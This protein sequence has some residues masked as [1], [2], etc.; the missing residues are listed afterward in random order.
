[1]KNF[2]VILQATLKSFIRDRLLQL[3]LVCALCIF[4]IVPALSL[5]SMRQVQELSVTLSLS[6]I[7]IILLTLTVILG[8]S[9]VWRDLDRR[10]LA[11][12]LGLPVSRTSYILGKF[13]G[14]VIFI[15][16]G[17]LLLGLVATAVIAL[18]SAQ[19]PSDVPLS[20]P[21]IWIAILSDG[22]KYV[23]VAAV[24]MLFSSLST[25]FYFPF[26]ATLVIYF[27]GSASQEVYEYITSDYGKTLSAV[28]RSAINSIY[29]CIPNFAAFDFKVHAVYALT[30]QLPGLLF[31]G[32]YFILYT[33][34]ILM[35]AVWAFNR[36]ELA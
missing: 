11:S 16:L 12:I 35:I 10:Y 13:T 27:C 36:R 15:L 19:Y 32:T 18:V 2:R 6:A 26:I 21:Q 23:L 31:A 17:C 22:L 14:I 9:S 28:T 30:L 4:L 5:F 1:M 20:W 25:S 7:S 34:I 8:S 33:S 3:L 24:A 29:Y